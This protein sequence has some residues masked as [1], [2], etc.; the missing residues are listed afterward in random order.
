MKK[1]IALI[2][3]LIFISLQLPA[4]KQKD[5]LYLKNGSIIYG[6]LVEI[7]E[8]QYKIRTSDGSLF[9]Y[10]TSEVDKFAR[11][12]EVFEGRKDE[13]FGIALEAGFLVGA[14]NT[15]YHMPFS[16]NILANYTIDTKNILSA[17]TGVEF[18]GVAFTPLFIEYKYLLYARKA[19]PFFFA[20]SGG[21]LHFGTNEDPTDY[22]PFNQREYKG[23]FSG[24]VGT[25]ISWSGDWTETYLSF[26]YRYAKTSYKQMNYNNLD[27][28]YNN[29]YNRLEIKLGFKF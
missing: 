6:K 14:Q 10:N 5:V 7:T 16:F 25:G 28:T 12:S 8:S 26:A 21:L 13:G 20:R 18:I 23:G 9:I 29:T 15:D 1:N 3:A 27:A 17:G 11:E 4:Q 2:I 19:T 22:N 24:A